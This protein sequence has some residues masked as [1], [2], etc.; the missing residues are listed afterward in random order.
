MASLGKCLSFGYLWGKKIVSG[1]WD[2]SSIL[3]Q[4]RSLL[5][6]GPRFVLS[7]ILKEGNSMRLEL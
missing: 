2:I 7:H 4:V 1:L 3:S 6:N 5:R